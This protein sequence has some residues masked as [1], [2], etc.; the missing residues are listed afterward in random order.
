MR[1]ETAKCG[2]HHGTSEIKKRKEAAITH[3]AG[4]A[5]GKHLFELATRKHSPGHM[6]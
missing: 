1:L 4:C 3:L 6:Q 5:A 2:P